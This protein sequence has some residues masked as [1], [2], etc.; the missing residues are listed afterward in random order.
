MHVG[1]NKKDLKKIFS[2]YDKNNNKTIE[3]S[4]FIN[5]ISDILKKDELLP[6]FKTYAK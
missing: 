2:K 3:Y 5:I 6:I 4:E 1:I